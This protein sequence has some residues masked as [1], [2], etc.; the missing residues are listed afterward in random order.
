[1][2]HK[3][4]ANPDVFNQM[5]GFAEGVKQAI[6]WTNT[7]WT[8]IQWFGWRQLVVTI[9]I[10]AGGWVYGYVKDEPIATLSMSAVSIFVALAYGWKLPVVTKLLSA[11]PNVKIWR[12][13][14]TLALWQAACLLD[15]ISPPIAM[16]TWFP[17]RDAE[18][19][20]SVLHQA[21]LDGEVEQAKS[22]RPGEP[23]SAP[24][25]INFGTLVTRSSLQKFA[26]K[27]GF[28]PRFL[29]S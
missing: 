1:V 15:D 20:Y 19:Y 12:H 4:T 7:L 6:A 27:R 9:A 25:M 2:I 14:N 11:K 5:M 29:N 21:V 22:R 8:I 10:A 18:A 24:D 23:I 26:A 28:N 13:A 17:T 3:N 16:G